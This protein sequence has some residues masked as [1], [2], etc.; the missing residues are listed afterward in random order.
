MAII[1][2][3]NGF[4]SDEWSSELPD[5]EI[6]SLESLLAGDATDQNKLIGVDLPPDAKT[7]DLIPYFENLS[8]ISIQFHSFAD[9]RGFSLA[10]QLRLKGYKGTLRATGHVLSDQFEMARKVGF[11]EVAIDEALSQRQPEDQWLAR[12]PKPNAYQEQLGQI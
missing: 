12:A 11:D 10:R 1:V 8:L 3:D 5:R 9:G 7:A 2:T 6:I 4:G